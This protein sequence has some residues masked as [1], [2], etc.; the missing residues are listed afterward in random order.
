MVFVLLDYQG[1]FEN[2]IGSILFQPIIGA[3]FSGFTIFICL[4]IGLPIRLNRLVRSWWSRNY[5]VAIGL[6]FIGLVLLTTALSF[7]ESYVDAN[8]TRQSPNM[9][10]ASSGWFISAFSTLH[11][12]PTENIITKIETALNNFIGKK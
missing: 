2:F 5:F 1:G 6:L 9:I 10:L 12:F 11:I 4:I 7:P 3:L 8:I